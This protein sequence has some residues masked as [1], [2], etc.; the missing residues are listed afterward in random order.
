MT[1][2]EELYHGNINPSESE[3]LSNNPEYQKLITLTA[4]AQ[5]KLK[6]SLNKEEQKLLDNYIKSSEKLSVIINEDV[7][8]T[9]FSLALKIMIETQ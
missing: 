5:D 4:Q 9:G 8:K 3:S 7:F 6:T 1:T 2:L